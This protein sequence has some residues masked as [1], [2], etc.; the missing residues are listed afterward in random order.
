MKTAGFS[1]PAVTGE[2]IMQEHF[3]QRCG[4]PSYSA[5]SP[6]DAPG[7]PHCGEKSNL[8]LV[9]DDR[10]TVRDDRGRGDGRISAAPVDSDFAGTHLPALHP[11][12]GGR[13]AASGDP[14][15]HWLLS[16]WAMDICWI[17]LAFIGLYLMV[18]VV[19]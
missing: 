13:T 11:L 15:D 19:R 4:Q 3:C 12:P 10:A 18:E 16:D 5:A 8:T 17:V 14:L 2:N 1:L 9:A 7:C 6:Q